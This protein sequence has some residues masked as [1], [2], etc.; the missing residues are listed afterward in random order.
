MKLLK[1]LLLSS[2]NDI[3]DQRQEMFKVAKN[4]IVYKNQMQVSDEE[5]EDKVSQIPRDHKNKITMKDI[6]TYLEQ[7]NMIF[8]GNTNLN[9]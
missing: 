5:E 3:E 4:L 9:D 7:N 2:F 6:D 8:N 1:D